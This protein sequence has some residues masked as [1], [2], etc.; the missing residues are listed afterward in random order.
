MWEDLRPLIEGRPA[1]EHA[2]R[3]VP[4]YPGAIPPV[5]PPDALPARAA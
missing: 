4:H 1:A 3:L 2:R 5:F